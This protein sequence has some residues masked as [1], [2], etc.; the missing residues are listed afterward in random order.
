MNE[1]INN[2]IFKYGQLARNIASIKSKHDFNV[3]WVE[4][5]ETPFPRKVWIRSFP[6]FASPALS[7]GFPLILPKKT[8]PFISDSSSHIK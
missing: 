1:D 6:R 4:E 7:C 5:A 3:A 2:S 8:V